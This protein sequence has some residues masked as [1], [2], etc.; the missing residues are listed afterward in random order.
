MDYTRARERM[1]RDQI[2]ARGVREPRV[3]A[4][5][6]EVPREQ[7]VP[8]AL[9]PW[10]CED[11]PLSIGRGQTISQPYMV[12][13]M[14]ELL[15]AGPDSTVLEI[16]AGCGYQSSVLSRL[17]KH[18]C[19]IER[20]E[21]LAE[22]TSKRLVG[23][24]CGN[25]ELIHGDGFLGWPGLQP[26]FERILVACAAEELPTALLD[27]LAPGGRLVIP[28]GPPDTKQDLTLVDRDQAGV[29]HTQVILPVRFV[30]MVHGSV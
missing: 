25:V 17:V 2:E 15:G 21:V 29:L 5:M 13:L 10:A 14:T 26:R 3:L 16:G 24:G 4:A 8:T 11:Q 19:A 22:E 30:P 6:R 12:A 28:V 23:M 7:F 27:Q 9:L 18:V 20:D 1:V